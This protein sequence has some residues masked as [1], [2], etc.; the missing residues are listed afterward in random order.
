MHRLGT[1]I[2]LCALT[3]FLVTGCGGDD[4]AGGGSGATA[5]TTDSSWTDQI[6]ADATPGDTA[7]DTTLPE[8]NAEATPDT[9]APEAAVETS[10]PET[11]EETSAPET[12]LICEP[13]CGEGFACDEGTCVA[14][15]CQGAG[16]IA[17]LRACPEGFVDYLLQGVVVTISTPATYYV[18][19]ASGGMQ[20]YL[21]QSTTIAAPAVG[22]KIDVQVNEYG[23]Y[24]GQ[25]EVVLSEAPTVVGAGEITPQD[26]SSGVAPSEALESQLVTVT[27]VTLTSLGGENGVAS[28]GTATGVTMRFDDPA[29]LCSGA[30]FDIARAVISEF[31][32]V[33]RVQVYDS[34]NALTNLNLAACVDHDDSNWSFEEGAAGDGVTPPADFEKGSADF[35]ATTTED[36]AHGG[37]KAC[38]LTWT[39]TSNQDFYQGMYVPVTPGKQITFQVYALDND[40]SGK[41]RMALDVYDADKASLGS[42]QYGDYTEDGADWQLM[43]IT[44][45]APADAAF[46]RGFVRLYDV[47]ES[48][49]GSATV[50]IDDWAVSVQ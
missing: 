42:K 15:G 30:T 33:H 48:W 3:L 1:V 5:D 11:G 50:F 10:T 35:E 19:D 9:I 22:E 46:V 18:Q 47:S 14:L 43:S 40:P 28:Y 44:M 34:A 12:S 41:L 6:P 29:G 26:L 31:D 37:S 20:I 39:S 36:Q 25:Q 4:A 27:G 21:G 13:A 2:T 17:T 16:D 38:E 45:E 23:S 32:G 7:I 24:K 49:T 8:A